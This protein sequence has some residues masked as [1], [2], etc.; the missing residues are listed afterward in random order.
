MRA[1]VIFPALV[2]ILA[3]P[4][5]WAGIVKQDPVGWLGTADATL[6]SGPDGLYLDDG[7]WTPPKRDTRPRDH[8]WRVGTP[9]I[10]TP[11]GLYLGCDPD[12]KDPTVRRFK[13]KGDHTRWVFETVILIR[14]T[15]GPPG[16][17]VE[18]PAGVKFKARM[19]A[20]PFEG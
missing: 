8:R 16:A 2:G 4:P 1:W 17:D 18:G 15:K 11:S 9:D 10:R 5:A 13:E 6:Y 7:G 20:G 14:P 19:A 3:V 12:G